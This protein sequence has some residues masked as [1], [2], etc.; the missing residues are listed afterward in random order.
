M[1]GVMLSNDKKPVHQA[2]LDKMG[3]FM[4]VVYHKG[5]KD[6]IKHVNKRKWI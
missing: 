4:E 6:T 1:I 2:H 5:R 3:N